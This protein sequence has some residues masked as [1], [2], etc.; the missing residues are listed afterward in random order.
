L[1]DI[2]DVDSTKS[3]A[4]YEDGTVLQEMTSGLILTMNI[5]TSTS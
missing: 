1:V 3:F 5:T 4:G 2:A